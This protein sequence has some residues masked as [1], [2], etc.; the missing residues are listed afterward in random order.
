MVKFVV[1]YFFLF[2]IS[3]VLANNVNNNLISKNLAVDNIQ[4]AKLGQPTSTMNKSK[5]LIIKNIQNEL[6][7]IKLI[8]NK[9]KVNIELNKNINSTYGTTIDVILNHANSQ[10]VILS[11]IITVIIAAI[12]FTIKRINDF[13]IKKITHSL[14]NLKYEMYKQMSDILMAHQHYTEAIL[15]Y[16][17]VFKYSDSI[18]E[19]EKILKTINNIFDKIDIKNY[20]DKTKLASYVPELKKTLRYKKKFETKEIKEQ[21]NKFNKNIDKIYE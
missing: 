15:F 9:N 20:E 5:G 1:F 17:R 2:S 10:I 18:S 13:K 16:I 21:I 12:G 11:I 6:D 3:F 7:S 19:K 4:N 14:N 8:I